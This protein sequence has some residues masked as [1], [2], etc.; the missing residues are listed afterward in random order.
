M[1]LPTRSW[2]SATLPRALVLLALCALCALAACGTQ[3]SAPS[4]TTTPSPVPS[5]TVDP[6]AAAALSLVEKS[7]DT[8]TSRSMTSIIS[9]AMQAPS[10]DLQQYSGPNPYPD[11]AYDASATS[12]AAILLPRQRSHSRGGLHRL[13]EQACRLSGPAQG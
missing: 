2:P 7:L 10:P 1:P 12:R 5:P 9:S 8:L 11:I 13:C 3:G 4:P 6:Q